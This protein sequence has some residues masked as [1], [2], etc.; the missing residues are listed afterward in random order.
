M[1]PPEKKTYKLG[2][3]IRNICDELINDLNEGVRDMAII[4]AKKQRK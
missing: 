2:P 3:A 4:K 1:N